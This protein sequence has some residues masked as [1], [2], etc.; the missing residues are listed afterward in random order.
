MIFGLVSSISSFWRAMDTASINCLSKIDNTLSLLGPF[1]F[2]KA[3]AA[4]FIS[5]LQFPKHSAP[6]PTCRSLQA[7]CFCSSFLH[8]DFYKLGSSK[9]MNSRLVAAGP[10]TSGRF[11]H[12][13][14]LL[15]SLSTVFSYHPFHSF[16]IHCHPYTVSLSL[17]PSV[18]PSQNAYI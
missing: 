6:C 13:N 18:S 12:S 3:S 5:S 1:V 16:H 17:L 4:R 15:L 11:A 10:S 9:S 2:T 14:R 7:R 8:V